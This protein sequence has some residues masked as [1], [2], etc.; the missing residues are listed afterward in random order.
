[1][2]IIINNKLAM[3]K[4]GSS[5]EFISENRFFTDADS[6]TLSIT[7]PLRGCKQ[8]IDIFGH[9]NRKDHDLDRLLLDCEIHDRN[10]HSYGSISIVEISEVEVK[11]QFLEGRSARNF[12]SALDDIYINEIEMPSLHFEA[13]K[14][15][16]FYCRTYTVQ[17]TD[18]ECGDA[19]Y[20]GFVGLPWVNNTSGNI[21]NELAYNGRNTALTYPAGEVTMVGQPFLLEILRQVL[22]ACGYS[23]NINI[24][25][26]SQWAN[27]IVC[28][29]F[30]VVWE[31]SAMNLIL[32]HWTVSEFLEQLELF[33]GGQFNFERGSRKLSFA[34]ND[35][36]LAGMK[37][38]VLQ[39][40]IDTH[41]VEITDEE[42]AKDIYMEQRNLA[43]ADCSHQM[44]KFYSCPWATKGGVLGVRSWT[45]IKAM[46]N[47]LKDFLDCAGSYVHR[48]YKCL[49][50]C[51]SESTYFVLRCVGTYAVDK[52]IHH[53]MRYQPV[54]VFGP[55]I[56]NSGED[57][58]CTNIGI[59]PACIDNTDA[60]RGDLIFVECGTLSDDGSDAEAK[61][62][63]QTSAVNT[64]AMGEKDKKE[65][66]FDKLYVAFWDGKPQ[67]Y[68]PQYPHPIIDTYEVLP[69]NTITSSG[70]SM[71]LSGPNAPAYRTSKYRIDQ[72][73][74]FTFSFLSDTIPD[75][76]SIFYVH[77]KRYL[78]EKITCSFSEEGMSRLLK[79]VAYRLI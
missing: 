24:L 9:I 27:V 22:D 48:Y 56:I 67:K 42:D 61:D 25:E 38:V 77:G 41:Q 59:V 7:F 64:L 39:N 79:M 34:F 31:M 68:F 36:T 74:K 28:N 6:Y 72:T 4:R 75:V 17:R 60:A 47:G 66:Y 69:D 58:E 50:F 12:Y 71:R 14:L 78:A 53:K 11:T 13:R 45:D 63:N 16:D 54:N 3:L 73:K 76:R 44:W 35:T 46:Q 18:Q 26:Q 20:L 10:F 21:Q 70:K 19:E 32:P 8:N 52:V 23:Y 40:V 57:A 2:T 43:Y 62:E 33:F 65:E 30:P 51:R 49:H 37:E 29:A 5:F 55:R 15:M 1:M